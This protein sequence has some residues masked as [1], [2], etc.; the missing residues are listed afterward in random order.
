M[1]AEQ[2]TA[3]DP[4]G[5][6]DPARA[7]DVTA[8]GATATLVTQADVTAGSLRLSVTLPAGLPRVRLAGR[9]F[10]ARCGDPSPWAGNH[11]WAIYLR[12]PLYVAGWRPAAPDRE[13]AERWL[14]CT[15]AR[16]DGGLA[17]LAAQPSGTTLD[18]IGPLGNGFVLPP[19]ARHLAVVST[20]GRTPALLPLIH[21]MLD[22]GGRV[23]VLLQDDAALDP[24]LRAQLPFAVEVHQE[25]P[26]TAWQTRLQ[27]VLAWAD[28]ATTA[29]PGAA[30]AELFEA[31]RAARLRV[32][33]DFMQVLVDAQLVCGYGACHAC[34]TP[35]G[36]GR[37]TRACVHGPVFDLA[38]LGK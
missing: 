5:L 3:F 32:E 17:W 13:G 27:A 26:G 37:W 34:L 8:G 30:T 20:P 21:E 11:H 19:R 1:K 15:P 36:A 16:D 38:E 25:A 18:L 29:L 2:F 35:L 10:L 12:R 33:R 31:T 24:A 23:V 6:D 4:S 28:V 22:R 14:L 7:L 9:Y